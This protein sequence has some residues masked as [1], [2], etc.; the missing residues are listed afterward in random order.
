M[1]L[2]KIVS[3][4]VIGVLMLIGLRLLIGSIITV[5][6]KNS[7]ERIPKKDFP[8]ISIIVPI[9]N[10]EKALPG[11][12]NK[13]RQ[14]SY[15]CERLQIILSY[16]KDCTDKSPQIANKWAEKVPNIEA[17]EHDHPIDGKG[18]NVNHALDQVSGDIVGIL[19]ADMQP[20]EDA[21]E[22]VGRWFHRQEDLFALRGQTYAYNHDDSLISLHA[23]V[24]RDLVEIADVYA[25]ELLDGFK[26]YGG[27]HIFFRYTTLIEMGGLDE[28]VFIDDME[29]SARIHLNNENIRI[30]PNIITYG[31]NPSSVR[32]WW[33][34]RRRWYLGLL[35]VAKRYTKL[36]LSSQDLSTQKR[37]DS[38][39][40][41]NYWIAPIIT[42]PFFPVLLKEIFE[43]STMHILDFSLFDLAIVLYFLPFLAIYSVYIRDIF[44]GRRHSVRKYFVPITFWIYMMLQLFVWF[45]TFVDDIVFTDKVVQ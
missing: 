38:V 15:P 12:L 23:A 44:D 33:N 8:K 11:T 19:D 16:E 26:I 7:P 17:I 18:K 31:K 35:Q 37:A 9:Y 10:E 24:E 6:R 41:L 3:I 36:L 5:Y 30:D 39:L 45:Y 21:I 20:T 34:Q 14:V 29:M 32:G 13:L 4:L 43:S 42:I 22:R 40:T 27:G 1:V 2:S 28:D 25:R